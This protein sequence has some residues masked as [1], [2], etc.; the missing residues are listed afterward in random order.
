[1]SKGRTNLTLTMNQDGFN[2]PEQEMR[3][4]CTIDNKMSET[5][6][7]RVKLQVLKNF[8]V[9]SKPLSRQAMTHEDGSSTIYRHEEVCQKEKFSIIK[10]GEEGAFETRMRLG[11]MAQ[12]SQRIADPRF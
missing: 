6:V 9:S 11:E 2:Q 10:S 7:K 4:K 8:E 1:M 5:D 12:K 3:F